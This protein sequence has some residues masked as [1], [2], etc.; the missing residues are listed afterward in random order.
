MEHHTVTSKGIHVGLL[1]KRSDRPD[2]E[3]IF[4]HGFP[5]S[6]EMWLGQ[7]NALPSN[8]SAYA[9]DIRGFGESGAGHRFFTIDLFANDLLELIRELGIAKPVVC[10]ISMGGYIALRAYEKEPEAFGGLILCDTTSQP[11]TDPARLKR[12]AGI[13]T[14]LDQGAAAYAETFVKN[15]FAESTLTDNPTPVDQIRKI[16]G[17]T[18]TET[19]ASAL[20]AMASRTDTTPVLGRI[21]VPVLVIRG[22]QDKVIGHDQALA[23]HSAIRNS[24][25]CTIS[26]SGH[27]PNLENRDE[28]NTVM[29]GFLESLLK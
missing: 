16:I 24:I 8:V 6:K 4:V 3:L 15:V 11:D 2:L 28:F 10:G 22:D 18:S 29:N 20:L 19:L 25:W 13:E 5:F 9:Y 7:L 23:L 1:H 21:E 17:G 26:A 14:I 27:L 12:F